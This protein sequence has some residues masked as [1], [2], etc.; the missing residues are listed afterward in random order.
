MSP[1][2]RNCKLEPKSI[3]SKITPKDDK[4]NST[5]NE[6]PL[7]SEEKNAS[8]EI[9][10]SAELPLDRTSIED[11]IEKSSSETSSILESSSNVPQSNHRFKGG[12]FVINLKRNYN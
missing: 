5:G 7:S 12:N 1:S 9:N 11:K 8:E 4:E 2:K 3:P 6:K 10:E